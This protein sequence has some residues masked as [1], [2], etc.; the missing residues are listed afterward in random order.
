VIIEINNECNSKSYDHEILKPER[1]H[2]LIELVQNKRHPIKDYR[3]YVSTSY[4]GR[5]IPHP[6]VV[7]I[8][9]YLL[10]HGNGV[11]NPEDITWMVEETRKIEG[12]RSMPILF[13]E[14]DHFDFDKP[15][16]NMLN[17]FKANASWGYFDFRKRGETLKKDDQ[18]FL[19][20][21]Q[22]IPV[23]WGMSSQRKKDFFNLLEKLTITKKDK[24]YRITRV[25]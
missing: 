18:A 11:E 9:D 4:G 3:L 12:Y 6:N 16:N 5:H 14:D 21:Y 10:L 20:G 23:D 24:G 7:K 19:E 15:V 1:V 13:N 17:A 25:Y 2:E 8:A 22:S